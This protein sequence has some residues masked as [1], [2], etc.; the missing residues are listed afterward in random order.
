MWQVCKAYLRF[1]LVISSCHC[2][3]DCLLSKWGQVSSVLSWN[4]F[5]SSCIN[6]THKVSVRGRQVWNWFDSASKMHVKNA[7]RFL[8]VFFNSVVEGRKYKYPHPLIHPLSRWQRIL[9]MCHPTQWPIPRDNKTTNLQSQTAGPGFDA[10]R[11]VLYKRP[12]VQLILNHFLSNNAVDNHLHKTHSDNKL[13][14][15]TP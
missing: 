12:V 3:F 2:T 4:I 14:Y 13:P 8:N 10:G 5:I 11:Y 6:E 7:L 9:I 1:I 15:V